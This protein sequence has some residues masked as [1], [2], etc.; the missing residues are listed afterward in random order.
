MK[1][2]IAIIAALIITALSLTGCFGTGTNTASG[3]TADQAEAADISTYSEDFEGLQKY[4][5]DRNTAEKQ[6]IYYA[7]VGADDGVRYIFNKNAYVEIYDFSSASSST[8]DSANATASDILE[9]IRDDGKFRL[10]EDGTAMTG[11]VT[12]SGNYVLAW[13]AS[14]SYD[15]AGKVATEELIAN[16]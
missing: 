14:R 6:E 5:T 7:M 13:D 8:A 4:V 2:I 3:S 9:D 11:V 1:R 16:W 15:Y 10:M 12:D